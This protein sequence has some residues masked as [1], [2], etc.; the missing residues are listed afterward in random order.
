MHIIISILATQ[1][2]L[3]LVEVFGVELTRGWSMAIV[4]VSSI[5]ISLGLFMWRDRNG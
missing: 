2:V 3:R 4:V 5:F 1:G